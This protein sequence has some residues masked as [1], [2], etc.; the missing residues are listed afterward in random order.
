MKYK[1]TII[2]E[3]GEDFEKDLQK[4]VIRE[5]VTKD[6]LTNEGEKLLLFE[7]IKI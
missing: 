6:M 5:V 4:G 1:L 3:V 7:Y 2:V